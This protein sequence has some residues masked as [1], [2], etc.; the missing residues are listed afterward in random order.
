MNQSQ[1]QGPKAMIVGYSGNLADVDVNGNL[2]T[3]QVAALS[4]ART[5]EIP[6]TFA[7]SGVNVLVA[8]VAATFVR[9]YRLFIVVAGATNITFQDSNGSPVLFTGAIPLQ[10]NGSITLD[11]ADEPW[12]TTTIAKGFNINSSNAVQVSGA[13]YYTQVA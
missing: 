12:F 4:V 7:S 5:T 8:G 9:V 2:Q 3:T 1:K 10:A 11:M 13:M 6:I